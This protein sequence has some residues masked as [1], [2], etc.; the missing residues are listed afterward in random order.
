MRFAIYIYKTETPTSV[1]EDS[2]ESLRFLRHVYNLSDWNIVGRVKFQYVGNAERDWCIVLRLTTQITS[3]IQEYCSL[4]IHTRRP[5]AG[6]PTLW[7]PTVGDWLPG[8]YAPPPIWNRVNQYLVY[9]TTCMGIC[10]V[11][12]QEMLDK[13]WIGVKHFAA[14]WEIKNFP[15]PQNA[16]TV[17]KC[18]QMQIRKG[19]RLTGPILLSVI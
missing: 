5:G 2:V 16:F 4:A 17:C 19:I 12:T 15:L 18:L 7:P 6:L 9:H 14:S 1:L 10:F 11:W 3:A 8:P 13:V